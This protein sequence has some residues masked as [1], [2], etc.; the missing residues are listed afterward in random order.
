M[1]KWLPLRARERLS[2][3]APAGT[4]APLQVQVCPQAVGRYSHVQGAQHPAQ[5]LGPGDEA[6]DAHNAQHAQH[7]QEG[8]VALAEVDNEDADYGQNGDDGVK[9]IPPA[10]A[11]CAEADGDQPVECMC[12]SAGLSSCGL[13]CLLT[14]MHAWRSRQGACAAWGVP[15]NLGLAL[16]RGHEALVWAHAGED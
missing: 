7:R 2:S 13:V 1:R 4:G 8:D 14:C 5:A 15:S 12:G 16:M 3:V 10:F 9:H 11:V 6:E